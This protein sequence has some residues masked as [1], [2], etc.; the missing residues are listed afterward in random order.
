MDSV[1]KRDDERAEWRAHEYDDDGCCVHCG[2]DGAEWWH[3]KHNTYE[4]LARPDEKEPLC[5]HTYE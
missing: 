5:R 1:N 4:G 2:F 3:W